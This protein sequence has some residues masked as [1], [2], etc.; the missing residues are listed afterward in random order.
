MLELMQNPWLAAALGLLWA[1][2]ELL[3]MWPSVKAN[4]VFQLLKNGLKFL[5]GKK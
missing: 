2:S 4:G 1:L 5:M 3:G